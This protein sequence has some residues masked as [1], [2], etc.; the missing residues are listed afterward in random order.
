LQGKGLQTTY[1]LL[2]ETTDKPGETTDKPG[3]TTDKPGEMTDKPDKLSVVGRAL[4]HSDEGYGSQENGLYG[5]CNHGNTE[6]LLSNGD[7]S[8]N[9]IHVANGAS[10][11]Y[12]NGDVKKTVWTNGEV[13]VAE[14][15]ITVHDLDTKDNC[16]HS[17]EGTV[18]NHGNRV[19]FYEKKGDNLDNNEDSRNHG[20][21]DVA[22]HNRQNENGVAHYVLPEP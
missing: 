9:S 2:G 16:N 22:L 17:D 18:G 19:G 1:W 5:S 14:E 3:E 6:G 4:Q 10:P 8:K 20:N 15:D 7:V 12:I 11:Q 21:N 13:R